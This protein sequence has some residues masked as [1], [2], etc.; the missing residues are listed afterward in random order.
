MDYLEVHSFA[1]EDL[2]RAVAT[3]RGQPFRDRLL[4]NDRK[5]PLYEV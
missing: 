2:D 3:L 1:G 4:A 5:C